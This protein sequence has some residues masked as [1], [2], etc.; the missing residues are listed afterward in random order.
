M[1]ITNW[2]A[3]ERPREKLLLHGAK[4]LSDAE[5]LAIFIHSGC[6]GKTAVDM[7]RELLS[8][9]GSLKKL[10]NS[11]PNDLLMKPGV[12]KAKVAL[13]KA[14][15]ELGR[16]FQEETLV[17]GELL[18]NSQAAQHFLFYRL[19]DY[20]HEVFACLFLDLQLRVL[21]FDEISHGTLHEANIYPREI[22]KLA[23]AHNA[24][25]IILAHNHPSGNI[26]PSQTDCDMTHLLK[27]SLALVDIQVIDHIIVGHDRCLSMAD[28]GHI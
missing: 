22:I 3:A 12:G 26:T 4:H 23:L 19:K 17:K 7:A 9:V 1:A 24:A 27:N 11:T 20:A 2:P 8:T 25:K 21:G 6:R 16:R 18:N 14:A 5:L 10:L 15:L 13:L 28:S